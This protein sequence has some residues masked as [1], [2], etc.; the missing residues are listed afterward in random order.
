MP[1]ETFAGSGSTLMML[2]RELVPAQSTTAATNG[3]GTPGAA[4]VTIVKARTVPSVGTSTL[5][6]SVPKQPAHA[7]RRSKNVA[8]HEVHLLATRCG[9]SPRTRYSTSGTWVGAVVSVTHATVPT[10]IGR[11]PS[12]ERPMA[13]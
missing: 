4:N 7:L 13:R 9:L 11:A 6:N 5:V 8:P 10:G 12:G 1:S 2:P 3:T